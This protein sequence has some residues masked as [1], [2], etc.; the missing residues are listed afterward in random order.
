MKKKAEKNIPLSPEG[1]NGTA[2]KKSKNKK[3]KILGLANLFS[4][5]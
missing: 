2:P 5:P 3:K 1:V 4:P